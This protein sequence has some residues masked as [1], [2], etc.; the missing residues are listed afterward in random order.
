[1]TSV[2][3]SDLVRLRKE[4]ILQVNMGGEALRFMKVVGTLSVDKQALMKDCKTVERI[5]W[6]QSSQVICI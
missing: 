2:A 6:M 3:L 4:Q 5:P 1:V